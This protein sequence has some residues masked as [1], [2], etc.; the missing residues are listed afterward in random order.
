MKK[1]LFFILTL[2]FGVVVMP[3]IVKAEI[4][5][6]ENG[7]VEKDD[8]VIIMNEKGMMYL[9]EQV[10][11]GNTYA[12]KYVSLASDLDFDGINWIPIGFEDRNVKT[13][14]FNGT[15]DGRDHSIKNMNTGGD[16]SEYCYGLFGLVKEAKL[17]NVKFDDS[18]VN[19]TAGTAGTLV[20]C[21]YG[22]SNTIENIE[23]RSNVSVYGETAGGVVGRAY[24]SNNYIYNTKNAATVSAITKAGGIVGITNNVSV[25]YD[26]YNSGLIK[27]APKGTGGIAGYL[28]AKSIV[29]KATNDADLQ[30]T[31]NVGGI[32]GYSTGATGQVVDATNNGTIKSTAT[33][34]GTFGGIIGNNPGGFS[35]QNST[36]NGEVIGSPSSTSSCGGIVGEMKNGGSV[37]NSLNNASL[38]GCEN[39]G[40]IAGTMGAKSFIKDSAGGKESI[41]AVSNAGR[42]VG[43]IYNGTT[44]GNEL[45]KGT[46]SRLYIDDNN[47]DD[48]TN[49]NTIGSISPYTSHSS[50]IIET[51]TLHGNPNISPKAYSRLFFRETADC[52]FIENPQLKGYKR[53][54][55][56]TEWVL[57]RT[58][59]AEGVVTKEQTTTT[60][61]TRE[62]DFGGTKKVEL[63][64][65]EPVVWL[66]DE[67]V[68]E[69]NMT[70]VSFASSNDNSITEFSIDKNINLDKKEI[71]VESTNTKAGFV[72]EFNDDNLSAE[73][74][75][76]KKV[77]FESNGGN[78]IDEIFVYSDNAE[79]LNDYQLDEEPKKEGYTFAGWYVDEQLTVKAENID[80][81]GNIT[82]YAKW[83][84]NSGNNNSSDP[85]NNS[86]PNVNNPKT[87]DGI[88]SWFILELLSVVGISCVIAVRKKQNN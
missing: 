82:L 51:G 24:S 79:E 4:V 18:N 46:D 54:V 56:K 22:N 45:I 74:K 60:T 77:S 39:S 8:R 59:T 68:D 49:L 47:G 83:I 13:I 58:A 78:D 81:D 65:A 64:N 28:N 50:V 9:A 48:Y 44:S 5:D 32:V 75:F 35:V 16:D 61:G 36:N 30:G 71:L 40:G 34:G 23:V 66:A 86:D 20:G 33:S 11:N 29:Y 6:L 10:N 3:N 85:T 87:Y 38:S 72:I 15:F 2:L 26:S 63:I 21:L 7:Y 84:D 62:Y 43:S 67:V 55:N 14:S 53:D 52:D 17:L 25:I 57:E 69:T 80:S 27:D 12:G 73:G 31:T 42:L 76:Y 41:T 19:S 88:M 37:I 70:N 1:R